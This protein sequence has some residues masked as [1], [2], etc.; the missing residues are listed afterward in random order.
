[1]GNEGYSA[2]ALAIVVIAPIYSIITLVY[3]LYRKVEILGNV[4]FTTITDSALIL[5]WI[6]ATG[7]M[8]SP[9]YVMWYV[10][11]VGVAFRYSLSITLWTTFLYLVLYMATFYL[12]PGGSAAISVEQLLVRMG[13]IPLAGMLG[14]Y[15]SLE[16]SDQ[17]DD[18]VKLARKDEELRKAHN[19][20]EQKVEQ[21]TEQLSIMNKDLVDSMNYAKRIQ[22]AILPSDELLK[23]AFPNSFVLNLARD[24][25]SGDFYWIHRTQS[26]TYF[27]VVDCTGH[28]VPG[29]L[30]SMIANS[31]L[32]KIIIENDV[33]DPGKALKK[34]DLALAKLVKSKQSSDAVNDGMDMIL[35]VINSTNELQYASAHGLGVLISDGKLKEL[36]TT[37]SSIGGLITSEEKYFDTHK[38]QLKKG[39]TL[40]FYS[41][42]FQDQF[43]GKKGKKY[44]RKNLYR[45]LL[46]QS[47][48]PIQE[49]RQNIFDGFSDWKGD[50]PQTDDVTILA[51][52]I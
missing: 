33:S 22:S 27:A 37:K 12:D 42:G 40:Y 32:N 26:Y 24:V 52:K 38:L 7:Y 9:F 30:M 10:S 51:F 15:V 49:Q 14:M 41:D 11:I 23:I 20:L 1:M 34:M 35:G 29:A 43:G 46:S 50:E 4:Y 28:G 39:D 5:L 31:L 19:Q 17:I 25:I 21:R 2:L 18:K 36:E 45:L 6:I 48:F 8:E 16:I 3:E 13:Y 47:Q 44:L